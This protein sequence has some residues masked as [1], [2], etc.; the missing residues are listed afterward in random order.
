MWCL[1]IPCSKPKCLTEKMG[2]TK[3]NTASIW[4][5]AS[6]LSLSAIDTMASIF[7]FLLFLVSCFVSYWHFFLSDVSLLLIRLCSSQARSGESATSTIQHYVGQ[8]QFTV[9]SNQNEFV[10]AGSW[11]QKRSSGKHVRCCSV[12]LGSLWEQHVDLL[13]LSVL[14]WENWAIPPLLYIKYG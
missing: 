2:I 13:P 4:Q 8:Q 1:C 14:L 7:P 11:G 3:V 12:L 6:D 5:N 10:L 9:W